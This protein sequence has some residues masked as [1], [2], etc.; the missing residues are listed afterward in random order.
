[1]KSCKI[2]LWVSEKWWKFFKN[3]AKIS[4]AVKVIIKYNLIWKINRFQ[5]C[6][7][8]AKSLEAAR[9]IVVKSTGMLP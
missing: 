2:L 4:L 5:S 9:F 8:P 1:M 6:L 7:L 3:D